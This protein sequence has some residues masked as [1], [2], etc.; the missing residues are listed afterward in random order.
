MDDNSASLY[1][2]A[3]SIAEIE[4]G[5]ARLRR[6]GSG[7]KANGLTA[8]L[9]ALLHLYQ[10]RVLP[11]DAATA[12]TAGALSDL[13][14]GRGHAPG[15]VD[16]AI[17]APAK[18]R[19]FAILTNNARHLEPVGVP[20]TDP[21]VKLPPRRL[22]RFEVQAPRPR[23]MREQS[24]DA[25][26]ATFGAGARSLPALPQMQER[27]MAG[28]STSPVEIAQTLRGISFPAD[29]QDLIEHASRNEAGEGVMGVLEELPEREYTNMADVEKAVG[30][31]M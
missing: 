27:D 13:A 19:G 4:A 17:A 25:V 23:P 6:Q 16:V 7:R 18:L 15:F 8:W 21:F 28:G 14:R 22:P 9:D 12:R 2:S 5:I 10:D 1:M 11:F 26:A 3:V 31:I 29:K 30:Q 20:F 24:F